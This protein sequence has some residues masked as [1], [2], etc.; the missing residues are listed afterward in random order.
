ME[1]EPGWGAVGQGGGCRDR[2]RWV[3]GARLWCRDGEEV[4]GDHTTSVLPGV[5]WE[6][7][8]EEPTGFLEHLGPGLCQVL[9]QLLGR[10]GSS[11]SKWLRAWMMGVEM[12]PGYN[13]A[14]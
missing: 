4:S 11:E 3:C 6:S 13:A 9:C 12:G 2:R 10:G 1:V 5:E 14:T 7:E 8:E